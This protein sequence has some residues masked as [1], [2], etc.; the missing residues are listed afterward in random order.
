MEQKFE[1]LK[2]KFH[3]INSKSIKALRRKFSFYSGEYREEIGHLFMNVTVVND[4]CIAHNRG[5]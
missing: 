1:N 2:D 5:V 4:L 3:C